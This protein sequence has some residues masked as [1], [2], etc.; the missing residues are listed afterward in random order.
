MSGGLDG[1]EIQIRSYRHDGDY[2]R[3]N[4]FLVD[5]Y[6]PGNVMAAWLQPRWEYMHFHPYISNVDLDAIGIAEIDGEI[7]GMIHPEHSPAFAYVQLRPGH[8]NAA[9]LLFDHAEER[10]GGLSQTFGRRV[11]GIY[12]SEVDAVLGAQLAA[13]GFT[14]HPDY[15]EPQSCVVAGTALP[16]SPIPDGFA[17][18]SLDDDNDLEKIDRVLWRGF[19]HEGA[20]PPDGPQERRRAQEAPNFDRSMTMVAVAPNG[21]YASFAGMWVVAQN[22]VGYV[23]PVATD[24]EYRR[25][26]LGR[27]AVLESMRRAFAAGADTIWVGSDQD[28]YKSLGFQ[29][30]CRN[31]FWMKDV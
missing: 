31:S 10:L 20:P 15:D 1:T 2:E 29:T 9:P 23:E 18:V 24:P 16:D 5:L 11:L 7:V 26:G 12:L 3:V 21:D 13:R 30:T 19:N 22:R 17:V 4:E 8:Q 27:A 14:A 6:Q 25:M 28:F